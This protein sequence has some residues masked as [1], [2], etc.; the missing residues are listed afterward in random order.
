[1]NM[2]D[3]TEGQS[4]EQDRALAALSALANGTRLQIVRFLVG[5]SH[6]VGHDGSCALATADSPPDALP[7]GDIARHVDASA[8]RLSFH[9]NILEQAGLIAAEKRGRQVLYRLDRP[10]MGGLIHYLL[11]DCCQN[12]PEVRA[13]CRSRSGDRPPLTLPQGSPRPAR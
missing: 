6:R 1:M 11:D 3:R 4:M 2:P 5:A 13:C 10:A 7:A 8:S 12:D 9:L